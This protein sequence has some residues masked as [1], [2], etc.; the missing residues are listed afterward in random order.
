MEDFSYYELDQN[1]TDIYFRDKEI[2]Y[3]LSY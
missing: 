1:R 2:L 3:Q